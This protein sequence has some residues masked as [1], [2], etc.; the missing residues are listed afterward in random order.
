MEGWE[1][2]D[3]YAPFYDWENARTLGCRDVPFWLRLAQQAMHAG[4]RPRVLELGCGTGRVTFPLW[5]A[6]VAMLGIDRSD[7]MLARAIKRQRSA[8][9]ARMRSLARRAAIHFIRGDIR[10][11]P[12]PDASFPMVI[13]PYGILQS[14]LRERDLAQT[15]EAVARVVRP[16]GTFGLE[17]VADLPSW[18]EYSRRVSLRGRRSNG[19]DVTLVESVRQ[20]LRRKLTLFDQEFVERQGRNVR[21]RRF[22]LSFRTLTVRQM[23]RRLERAGFEITA[24]LGDYQGGPWDERAEAWIIIAKKRGDDG[25]L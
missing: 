16:G 21:R 23:R 19:V 13:A 22:T 14:L 9:Q 5:R 10:Q 1:G 24:L 7:A 15:L 3:D 17:L 11:L 25:R 18:Q 20:D 2:W 4:H 8:R 6:G 12:F